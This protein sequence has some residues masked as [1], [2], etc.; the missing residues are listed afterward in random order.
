MTL[1]P[2]V[3]D[4]ADTVFLQWEAVAAG[5]ATGRFRIASA[6]GATVL[7]VP[8]DIEARAPNRAGGGRPPR[9]GDGRAPPGAASRSAISRSSPS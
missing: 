1:S 9:P 6:G 7:T 2:G 5:P 3:L 8:A 4:V